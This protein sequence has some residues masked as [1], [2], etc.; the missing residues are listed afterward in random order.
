MRERV[1]YTGVRMRQTSA[2]L[3]TRRNLRDKREKIDLRIAETQCTG[4]YLV[5][6]P[7]VLGDYCLEIAGGLQ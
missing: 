7:N 4:I 3:A 5:R 6:I 1:H 2:C